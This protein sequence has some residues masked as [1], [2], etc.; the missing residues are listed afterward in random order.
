MLEHSNMLYL[1]RQ[2]MSIED[3]TLAMEAEERPR[4]SPVQRP[5]T[6]RV[7][8]LDMR[9]LVEHDADPWTTL[10]DRIEYVERSR[11]T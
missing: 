8:D 6:T 2:A 11:G 3:A 5:G 4:N 7:L 1:Y 10:R 9:L